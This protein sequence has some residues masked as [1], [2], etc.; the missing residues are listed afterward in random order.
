MA[1]E[2]DALTLTCLEI[3]TPG[4]AVNDEA[5]KWTFPASDPA[6]SFFKVHSWPEVSTD[7][8][9]FRRKWS[10]VDADELLTPDRFNLSVATRTLLLDPLERSDDP[11]RIVCGSVNGGSTS[12]DVDVVYPPT[13]TIR[14]V[15]AFGIPVVE[16][17]KI[18]MVS[19]NM[20]HPKAVLRGTAM[21]VRM[22]I[23]RSR[24]I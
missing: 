17:M 6:N 21:L 9:G 10:S 14:R 13:F 19:L 15:P 12:I 4:R 3:L 1:Q 11:E 2:G 20:K 16:G 7:H 18:S 23:V 22:K 24:P 5:A 8:P